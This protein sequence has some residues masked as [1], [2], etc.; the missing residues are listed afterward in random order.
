[1]YNNLLDNKEYK[2]GI[3]IRLSQ[4][5]R[6]KKYES[7]SESVRNQRGILMNYVDTNGFAF[8][9]EYVDDGYSGT[10]FDRPAFQRMIKDIENK[11]INLVIVKDLS[12]LG[13][14]HVNTGY[15]MERFF[16]EN[17]VRFISI[18]ESYDSAKV[19]A[20]NDSS[21]FIVACNDYYSKQNSNKIRDVLHSKKVQGK[22]IGSVPC[23]GYMRDPQDKGHLI[24]NPETAPIVKEIFKFF[25]SGMSIAQI[26]S[27]LNERSIPTPSAYKKINL[28]SSDRRLT[29]WCSS[30]IKKILTNRMYTGD[31]VQNTQT[32]INYKSKKKVN[33]DKSLWII[34]ENTHEP[35]VDKTAFEFIQKNRFVIPETRSA[36]EK[37]LFENL[38]FCKECGN[39]LSLSHRKKIDYWSIN[40]NRYMRDPQKHRCVSHFMPYEKLEKSL[41]KHI[42]ATLKEYM[43]DISIEEMNQILIEKGELLEKNKN[44]DILNLTKERDKCIQKVDLLM[45]Q[46]MDGKIDEATF[47]T[48]VK[49]QDSKIRILT[50][51]INE[52]QLK[53]NSS[54]DQIVKILDY[55]E[56]IKELLD[57]KNPTRDLMFAL[58][59]RIEIDKDRNI[60]ITYKFDLVNKDR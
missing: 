26:A 18:M 19:Q 33:L 45:D 37:R 22:Y 27:L 21:T 7:D 15:F 56:R 10:N 39:Y 50:R 43:D 41:L 8:I 38:L 58:I 24:P 16:P 17:R 46:Q 51:K 52:L 44:S 36:R 14:D 34:V 48:L 13:R 40:C 57:L 31:M 2:A 6:D 28:N 30:S 4:E 25:S 1:M 55:K 35:L 47:N 5:D 60:E 54:Q 3:Y 32:K 42:K 20:S 9:E 23:Y 49:D 11:K 59:D 29:E 12:R 53:K